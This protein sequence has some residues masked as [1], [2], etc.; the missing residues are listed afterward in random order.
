LNLYLV[1]H[2]EA[3][4]EEED[5]ERHLSERGR[6]EVR[7]IAMFLGAGDAKPEM[8]FHSGRARARETAEMIAEQVG[9]DGE[10]RETDGLG[11][12]DDP[13]LWAS[14]LFGEERDTMLVGHLPHLSKL[15]SILLFGSDEREALDFDSAAVACLG[16]GGDGA[17]RLRW[18]ITPSILP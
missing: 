4:R 8:I 15:A 11:P 1:R 12:R 6:E 13:Q 16:R 5:P 14:R 3:K 7:R 9:C 17:W 18:M 2:G 10:A